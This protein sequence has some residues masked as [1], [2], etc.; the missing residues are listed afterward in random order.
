MAANAVFI[1][2]SVNCRKQG[3]KTRASPCLRL[4]RRWGNAML[5]ASSNPH[6]ARRCSAKLRSSCYKLGSTEHVLLVCSPLACLGAKVTMTCT[7]LMIMRRCC[8]Q[9]SMQH[10]HLSADRNL[11]QLRN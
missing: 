5:V 2:P 6:Q 1:A 11:P 9:Q 3:R 7:C 4:D 10:L 8:M